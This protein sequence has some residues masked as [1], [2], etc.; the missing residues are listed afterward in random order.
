MALIMIEE[1]VLKDILD[2]AA[3]LR[4]VIVQ[5]YER[6]RDKGLDEWL[7]MEQVCGILNI[8]DA[9]VRSLKRSGRIGYIKCGKTCRFHSGDTYNLLERVEKSANG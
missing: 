8:S 6:I 4:K 9:K 2:R 5:F 1:D 7:I 3:Y